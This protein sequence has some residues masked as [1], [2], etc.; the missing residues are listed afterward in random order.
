MINRRDSTNDNAVLELKAKNKELQ[1]ELME[2][3][4]ELYQLKS[5][6]K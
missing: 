6:F 3:E 4:R 1:D 2:K 5:S